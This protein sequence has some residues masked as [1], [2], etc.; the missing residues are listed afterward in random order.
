[1]NDQIVTQGTVLVMLAFFGLYSVAGILVWSFAVTIE[2]IAYHRKAVD[3]LS[4]ALSAR[5]T[6]V[7]AAITTFSSFGSLAFWLAYLLLMRHP[8]FQW[9]FM[10]T[11]F[12]LCL[13]VVLWSL[14]L[15]LRL[16]TRHQPYLYHFPQDAGF[17]RLAQCKNGIMIAASLYP[18]TVTD[19]DTV[20][21]MSRAASVSMRREVF[22]KV[23]QRKNL[24]TMKFTNDFEVYCNVCA[25]GYTR[26]YFGFVAAMQ[27]APDHLKEQRAILQE[28]PETKGSERLMETFASQFLQAKNEE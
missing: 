14:T 27:A 12:L 25:E 15:Y 6:V 23:Q 11:L 1:M 22:P 17:V 5:R 3:F 24:K 10:S 7:T 19:A 8:T 28:W 13:F 16:R 21:T 9:L 4:I 18:K 26:G 20:D 2:I